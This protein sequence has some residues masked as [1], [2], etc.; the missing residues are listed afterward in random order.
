MGVRV[1]TLSPG[2][3]KID[4]RAPL[5]AATVDALCAQTPMGRFGRPEEIAEATHFLLSDAASFVTGTDL[6]VDGGWTAW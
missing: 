4:D 2:M 6:L 5:D 1:N 3:I